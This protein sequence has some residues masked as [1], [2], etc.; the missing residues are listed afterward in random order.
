MH[1]EKLTQG[2]HTNIFLQQL[3]DQDKENSFY[4]KIICVTPE[5][6]SPLQIQKWLVDQERAVYS[7]LMSEG[8]AIN[9][10]VPEIVTTPSALQEYRKEEDKRIK[11]RNKEITLRIKDIER[12]FI[13]NRQEMNRLTPTINQHKS[14]IDKLGKVIALNTGWK[15]LLFG[16]ID[17]T[18]LEVIKNKLLHE[19]ESLRGVLSVYNNFKLENDTLNKEK[20]RLRNL[21]PKNLKLRCKQIIN[22]Y[23]V[24]SFGDEDRIQY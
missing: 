11:L 10:I 16:N 15:K 18:D 19:H 8:K 4:F 17:N 12:I 9:K 2:I 14:E 20:Y 24:Q 21:Y 23:G 3:W 5:G 13:N 7:K 22:K 1:R 6:L